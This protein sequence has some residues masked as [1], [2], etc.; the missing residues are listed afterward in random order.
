MAVSNIELYEE[1][2][3]V[4]TPDAARMIA[5]VVPKAGD[6]ATKADIAMLKTDIAELRSYIDSRL[7]RF[8]MVFF[9]PV[10]LSLLGSVGALVALV[11]HG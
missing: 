6:V 7:L 1:L 11:V 5:E 9:V 4:L 3:R 10:A 2:K 8:A